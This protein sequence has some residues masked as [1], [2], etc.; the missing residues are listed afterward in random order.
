MRKEGPNEVGRMAI[1]LAWHRKGMNKWMNITVCEKLLE[2]PPNQFGSPS[3]PSEP[4]LFPSIPVLATCDAELPLDASDSSL[5][6]KVKD[7]VPFILMPSAS[8]S[9]WYGES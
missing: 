8:S 2:Q 1:L 4:T 9:A 5:D 3:F 7:F 6:F